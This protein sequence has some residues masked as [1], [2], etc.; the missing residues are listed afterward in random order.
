MVHNGI[1][2][3]L[4]QL[5]SEIYDLLKKGGD[6]NNDELHQTYAKME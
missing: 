4:M 3:G 2:Y 5:T 6:F 1:E